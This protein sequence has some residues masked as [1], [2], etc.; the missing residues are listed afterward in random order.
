MVV[1]AG[2]W[3]AELLV[4]SRFLKLL[5]SIVHCIYILKTGVD[6]EIVPSGISKLFLFCVLESSINFCQL[7]IS[8]Y[9]SFIYLR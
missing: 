4:E 1:N 6:N 9:Y 8:K 7:F 3:F 2:N 5:L